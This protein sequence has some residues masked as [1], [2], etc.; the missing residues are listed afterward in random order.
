MKQLFTLLMVALLLISCANNST[1][2]TINKDT[3][4][5]YPASYLNLRTGEV[6]GASRE[7]Y[8]LDA[9]L[10]IEPQDPEIR[11]MLWLEVSY[12]SKGI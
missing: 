11:N 9:D 2:I 8:E 10:F 12:L 4:G 6:K 3:F 7:D 1:E 5:S